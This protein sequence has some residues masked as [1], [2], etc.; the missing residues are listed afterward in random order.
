MRHLLILAAAGVLAGGPALASHDVPKDDET[1]LRQ[2]EVLVRSTPTPDGFQLI[3]AA[4]D[5]PAPPQTVWSVVTDCKVAVDVFWRLRKC[6][7]IQADPAGRW[8]VRQQNLTNVPLVPDIRTTFRNDYDAPWTAHFVQ[9][10]GDLGG[11]RGE[12][13]L[14]PL[15]GGRATRLIYEARVR[16]P[17]GILFSGSL[18]R[19]I[20]HSDAADGLKGL[21][22]RSV[23]TAQQASR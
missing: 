13:R 21:R 20:I 10:A 19:V 5:I 18:V 6:K 9:V 22:K 17:D 11:T 3:W 1:R 12:W 23:K 14:E 2:G 8:D 4:E 15:D 16:M 7:V